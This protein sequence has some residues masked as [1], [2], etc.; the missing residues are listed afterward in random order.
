MAGDM[1][2]D[3][4]H[5]DNWSMYSSRRLVNKAIPTQRLIPLYRNI[6]I[7]TPPIRL[8]LLDLVSCITTTDCIIRIPT[9][10]E[11]EV[12][13]SQKERERKRVLGGVDLWPVPGSIL[14][15]GCEIV[16]PVLC[17][18]LERAD[19]DQE[20]TTTTTTQSKVQQVQIEP[21]KRVDPNSA[22]HHQTGAA[23]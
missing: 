3:K 15:Q 2:G 8:V 22:L 18:L 1:E 19:P 14:L 17:R 5:R 13:K 9:L 21:C 23:V 12:H 7:T 11:D 6:I 20:A 4:M 10:L 16:R